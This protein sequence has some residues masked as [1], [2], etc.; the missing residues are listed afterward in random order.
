MTE[1]R[2][3][4][5]RQYYMRSQYRNSTTGETKTKYKRKYMRV[6]YV[7]QF[8]KGLD[9]TDLLGRELAFERTGDSIIIRPKE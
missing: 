4:I 1:I 3:V 5:K 7:V 9:V 8:P 6:V 2:R